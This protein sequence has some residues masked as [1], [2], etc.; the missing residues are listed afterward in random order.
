LIDKT[1][2]FDNVKSKPQ[3]P[4]GATLLEGIDTVGLTKQQK[5]KLKRKIKKEQ[6]KEEDSHGEE[7]PT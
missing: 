2:L 4:Q 7:P 6:Q 1:S 3:H 5:K